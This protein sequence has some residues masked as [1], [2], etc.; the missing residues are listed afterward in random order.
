MN[1]A[2]DPCCPSR[3]IFSLFLLPLLNLPLLLSIHLC[4]SFPISLCLL[5]LLSV[6]LHPTLAVR[7]T[8]SYPSCH[9]KGN[10]R[11]QQGET[12]GSDEMMPLAVHASALAFRD[13]C[14]QPALHP[15]F[16]FFT[17]GCQHTTIPDAQLISAR[18]H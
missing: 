8:E 2:L 14:K 17:V 16:I 7:M 12:G 11:E 18:C 5:D 9:Q 13:T 10:V 6:L 3:N 4:F 1:Y 15:R